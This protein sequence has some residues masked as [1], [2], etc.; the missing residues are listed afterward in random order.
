MGVNAKGV[1][2]GS[3]VAAERM[4]AGDGGAIINVSS[5]QGLLGNGAYPHL[6][7]VEGSGTLLTYSLAHEFG[8]QG[9]RVNAIHPGSIETELAAQG[10]VD[11]EAAAQFVAMTP[12]QR[13]GQPTDVAGAAVFLASDL[14]ATQTASRSSSTA[15]TPIPAER[16]NGET[17]PNRRT[18]PRRGRA[19]GFGRVPGHPVQVT[20]VEHR[21]SS[22]IGADRSLGRSDPEGLASDA[23]V[24]SRSAR[25]SAVQ[26]ILKRG[27]GVLRDPRSVADEHALGP[28]TTQRRTRRHES[29][30]GMDAESLARSAEG[31]DRP[32]G[33]GNHERS[34]VLLVQRD[35]APKAVGDDRH[36]P[37]AGVRE[38]GLEG[39]DPDIEVVDDRVQLMG[40]VDGHVVPAG[41]GVGVALVSV[42]QNDYARD[43]AQLV[44]SPVEIGRVDRVDHPDVP[45]DDER[46]A[47]TL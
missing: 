18:E 30:R 29:Q 24:Q 23:Q 32:E 40:Q 1:F 28:Q 2:F 38:F 37:I 16:S 7:H 8:S 11:E 14:R 26:C 44:E 21:W 3:Q 35:L 46:V 12:Q 34:L 36:R 31:V 33:F 22:A 45:V 15:G 41:D 42:Q 13:S 43:V 25:A 47:R 4:V 27:R 6:Q 10:G 5:V 20:L 9:I 39:F 17:E 19:G